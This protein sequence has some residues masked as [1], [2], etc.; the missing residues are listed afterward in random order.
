MSSHL[1]DQGL[2]K[3]LV[4]EQPEHILP[5]FGRSILCVSLPITD[6]PALSRPAS[7]VV[8]SYRL[9]VFGPPA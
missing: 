8:P 5:A 3:Q 2:V 1:G 9:R 4:E 7:L 6:L